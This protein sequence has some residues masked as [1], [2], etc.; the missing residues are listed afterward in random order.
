M[1][2][3]LIFVAVGPFLGGLLLLLATTVASEYW[4]NWSEVGTFLAIFARTLQYSYLF[5]VVPALMF[6]AIDDVLLHVRKIS[7][8]VRMLIVGAA[9][10]AAAE[11]LHG[12]RGPESG[13]VQFILH[14]LSGFMPAMISSWLA[15]KYVETAAGGKAQAV[16]A[17]FHRTQIHCRRIS[18][19]IPTEVQCSR[20]ATECKSM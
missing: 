10:F 5:G 3:Y 17:P 13:V 9:G 18:R 11:L 16:S 19:G 15:H 4:T 1:K 8:L 20:D 14:G 12:L 2:R 6:G 7:P